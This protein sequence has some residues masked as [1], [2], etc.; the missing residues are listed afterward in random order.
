MS[1]LFLLLGFCWFNL[2]FYYECVAFGIVHVLFEFFLLCSVYL[3]S[4]VLC[5][6]MLCSI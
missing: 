2:L 5:Y 3:R 6:V 1:F 4:I